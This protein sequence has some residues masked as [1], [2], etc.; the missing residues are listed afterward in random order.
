MPQGP[1]PSR[2]SIKLYRLVVL[3]KGS[4]KGGINPLASAGTDPRTVD[5]VT[6]LKSPMPI[7]AKHLM[8]SHFI[9]LTLPKNDTYGAGDRLLKAFA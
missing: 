8:K 5:S 7:L 2:L 6:N 9:S 4:H 3:M 1:L